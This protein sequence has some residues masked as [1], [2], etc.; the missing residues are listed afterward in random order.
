MCCFFSSSLINEIERHSNEKKLFG[1]V[2][3]ANLKFRREKV[4]AR[5]LF[6]RNVTK[7]NADN[8]N[9]IEKRSTNFAQNDGKIIIFNLKCCKWINRQTGQ[10]HNSQT[11]NGKRKRKRKHLYTFC[12]HKL[13]I[14]AT[15]TLIIIINI[16]IFLVE[17][18][19]FCPFK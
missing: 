16:H 11:P 2:K 19:W 10:S 13:I 15:I 18:R 8:G 17:M 9:S 4:R 3:C 5:A 12:V 14:I 6:K 7:T 1:L